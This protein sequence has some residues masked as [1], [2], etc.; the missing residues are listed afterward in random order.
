[1]LF[2]EI[3]KKKVSNHALSASEIHTFVDGLAD[4]KVPPEQISALCM[5]ILFNGMDAQE[6]GCLIRELADSGE[7]L[8]WSNVELDGP[9]VDKHSTGGVGDK[10]SFA[11]ASIMAACGAYVPMISGRGLGHTGGT[12]DKLESIPGYNVTTD[13]A[14]FKRVVKEVGC[15]IIGQTAELAPAD[16]RLYAIRDITSTV[17]SIPLICASIL[18]KKYASG[19]SALVMDIKSGN[20][21]FMVSLDN[22]RRLARTMIDS[23]AEINLKTVALITDMSEILGRTA[24]NAL[25][26]RESLNYL[27]NGYRNPRLDEVTQA[28]CTRMLLTAGLESDAKVARQRVEQAISSGKAAEIF[29]R[30]IYELGGPTNFMETP[31][32]Y[33]PSATVIAPVYSAEAGFVETVDVCAIGNMVVALGGGRRNVGDVVDHSVGLSDAA[34][35]GESV[36]KDKPLAILH[37]KNQESFDRASATLRSAYRL[38]DSPID[39]VPPVI[40]YIS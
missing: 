35:I 34:A 26:I 30:M 4:N 12:L 22:S 20:G 16:G 36:G 39:S 23:A 18:S 31:D 32:K 28:I 2:S 7:I 17:E 29:G 38:T 3:I 6:T 24:G 27:K 33:L 8:D 40:E 1:M 9:L 10:T 11:I 13:I 25:E 15:A 14:T 21:S 5:A 19:N 37:A